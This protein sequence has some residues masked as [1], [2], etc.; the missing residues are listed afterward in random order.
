M[1]RYDV[2]YDSM[3]EDVEGRYV[4]YEDVEAKLRAFDMLYEA[5]KNCTEY[6]GESK[7]LEYAELSS[8]VNDVRNMNLR[9]T[10]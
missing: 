8:I 2:Y 4:K 6:T 9:D 10:E 7:L 1:K 3:Q 5:A